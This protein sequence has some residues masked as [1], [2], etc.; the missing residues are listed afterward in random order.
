MGGWVKCFGGAVLP[1]SLPFLVLSLFLTSHTLG[2]ARLTSATG[3][4]DKVRDVPSSVYTTGPVM[5]ANSP[6]TGGNPAR[7][8]VCVCL[9]T[10]ISIYVQVQ[11]LNNIPN[12]RLLTVGHAL[13]D[14]HHRDRDPAKQV[15]QRLLPGVARQPPRDGRGPEEEFGQ[16]PPPEAP[17]LVDGTGGWE[18]GGGWRGG[19]VD[20][21]QQ[22][23]L[24]VVE[25]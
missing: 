22:G 1:P 7:T 19:G 8:A 3:P 5:A 9:C 2:S 12:K 15:P 24:V 6:Y 14:D 25:G 20:P 17:G 23:G 16:P 11:Q 13:R 10:D 4:M 21:G 18:G